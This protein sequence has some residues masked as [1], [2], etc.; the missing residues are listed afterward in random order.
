MTLT[1]SVGGVSRAATLTVE[2]SGSGPLPAPSL[3]SPAA[4]ARF[5]VGQNIVFD[6]SDVSGAVGY[7]IAID[8]QQDFSSP[9]VLKTG[10]DVDV[11]HQHAAR[12]PDVV[13]G[14]R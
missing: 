1:A 8:N 9:T 7:T 2:P 13:P 14:P 5:S 12:H 6:W 3:L 11:L 10:H 4:D